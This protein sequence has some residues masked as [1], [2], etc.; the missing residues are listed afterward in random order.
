[1]FFMIVVAS[2][3]IALQPRPSD[4]STGLSLSFTSFLHPL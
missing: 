2:I 3:F 1:M 4:Q